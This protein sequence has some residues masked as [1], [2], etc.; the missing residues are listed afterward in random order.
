MFF[1]MNSGRTVGLP[2]LALW[3]SETDEVTVNSP[4]LFM[5]SSAGLGKPLLL[6]FRCNI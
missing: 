3:N 5:R 4:V 1:V 6:C 2:S